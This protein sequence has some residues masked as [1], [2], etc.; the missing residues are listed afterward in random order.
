MPKPKGRSCDRLSEGRRGYTG[1]GDYR[2]RGVDL[3]L[4]PISGEMLKSDLDALAPLGTAVLLGF[5]SGPQAGI[6]GEDLAA[7]FQKSVAVRVSD[8][9][10][11]FINRPDEFSADLGKVFQLKGV[12]TADRWGLAP[13]GHHVSPVRRI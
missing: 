12:P 11:Y 9:Y 4:N 7:H 2:G 8:I 10:T 1:Q 6:F 3:T 13:S 5:L